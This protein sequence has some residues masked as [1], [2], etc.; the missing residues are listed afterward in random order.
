MDR[1]GFDGACMIAHS[2][3][4]MVPVWLME[5]APHLVKAVVLLDPAVVQMQKPDLLFNFLYYKQPL[6]SWVGLLQS[7][8]YIN[9]YLR[10]HFCWY[11]AAVFGEELRAACPAVLVFSEKDILVSSRDCCRMLE[12]LH[13]GVGAGA[14]AGAG[15]DAA[16][17]AAT[18]AGV[19]AGGAQGAGVAAGVTAGAGGG[20]THSMTVVELAGQGH[21]AF[22][23]CGAT[24]AHLL[25][26]I[27]RLYR[28]V[29]GGSEGARG[30]ADEDV[31]GG[32]G[33]DWKEEMLPPTGGAS[34]LEVVRFDADTNQ[35]TS[36][37]Y[38]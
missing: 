17:P 19:G 23:L 31:Q 12:R 7:E 13:T 32:D 5:A 15:V 21:G 6:A 16:A 33:E 20:Q 29:A 24:Q 22:L 9:H 27:R 28:T 3:G 26:H 38:Y 25:S 10:R 37:L 8:L 4:T 30:V 36:T 18:T 11:T 35:A 1:F 34:R 2:L 14:G